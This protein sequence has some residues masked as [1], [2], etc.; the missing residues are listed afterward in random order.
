MKNTALVK[1][2]FF[3]KLSGRG[4]ELYIVT[5]KEIVMAALPLM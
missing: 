1:S 2:N 4:I 3:K 5:P